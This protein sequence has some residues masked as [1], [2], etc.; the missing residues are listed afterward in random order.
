MGV[1]E[2]W[3]AIL[4]L[5]AAL[6]PGPVAAQAAL[7]SA[8]DSASVLVPR[9]SV[10]A[11]SKARAR[12]YAEGFS[13][14]GKPLRF[15]GDT[16][17]MSGASRDSVKVALDH[18]RRLEVTMGAENRASST[19]LG[20][21]IGGAAGFGLTWGVSYLYYEQAGYREVGYGALIA[22]FTG[23]SVGG[24]VGA[25]TGFVLGGPEWREVR[26]TP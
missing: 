10:A 11:F 5:G 24:L 15:V 21:L 25:L 23:G 3:F 2:V 13:F 4:V 16:L 6:I 17:T 18:V 9:D 26:L 19:L 14:E 7:P 8:P 22:A 1:N 12:L 20:A